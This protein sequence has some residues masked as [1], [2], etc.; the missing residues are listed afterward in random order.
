M[1]TPI[2]LAVL[3]T[4]LVSGVFGMAGGLLLLLLLTAR[5]PLGD[6]M[7]LHGVA[8]LIANGARALV[9]LRHVRLDVLRRYAVG[10]LAAAAVCAA[11]DLVVDTRTALVATG[12]IACA[13]PLLSRLRLPSVERRGV[14]VLCGALVS[15]LHLTSGAPG[16]VLDVF[17]V[18]S[19]LSRHE[20]VA[21]KAATQCVGH[22]LKIAYFGA[23]AG[24][25]ASYGAAAW[26][27]LA[28]ASVAGTFAGRAILDRI[29]DRVFRRGARSLLWSIGAVTLVR[30][31]LGGA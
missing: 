11:L 26:T 30:G 16:P 13:E 14:A 17:F 2:L 25:S 7:V 27:A 31:V 10:A 19:A 18:R 15:G 21:T 9:S 23:V 12:S 28:A 24:G 1:D 3:L 29:D 5:M 6:A 20:N 4:A 22:A 8:Q